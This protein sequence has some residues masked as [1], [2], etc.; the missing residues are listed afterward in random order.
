MA[1][2]I[3]NLYGDKAVLA[4]GPA[5][6]TGFYYDI[7]LDTPISMEDWDALTCIEML[8]GQLTSID[9][10]ADNVCVIRLR[11]PSPPQ[12]CRAIPTHG[13]G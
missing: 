3:Q 11:T 12:R 7:A 8:A 10:T 4:Y 2:A 13:S 1:E 5:L 9:G 6:E